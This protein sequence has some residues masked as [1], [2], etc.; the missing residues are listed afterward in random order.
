MLCRAVAGGA[1]L[2][3]TPVDSPRNLLYCENGTSPQFREWEL[4]S[5]VT[6]RDTR[7]VNNS[8]MCPGACSGGGIAMSAGG[9]LVLT[10]ATIAGNVASSFGGGLLLGGTSSGQS[11]CS[12]VVNSSYIGGNR[13]SQ[14]GDQVYNNCGGG[15]TMVDSV[16]NLSATGVEVGVYL[17]K[18][19]PSQSL[20]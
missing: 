15:V 11:S 2:I 16:V 19:P 10:N 5:S 7:I 13:A 4:Y 18:V 9:T 17:P 8:V 20:Q 1:V 12:L 3:T 6:V 14:A